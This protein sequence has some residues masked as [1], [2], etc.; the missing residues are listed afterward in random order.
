[1]YDGEVKVM[2]KAAGAF[3]FVN[4]EVRQSEE[5]SLLPVGKGS[6]QWQK[7]QWC[8]ELFV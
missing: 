8:A 7:A 6:G 3:S 2:R 1:M 4:C 5:L